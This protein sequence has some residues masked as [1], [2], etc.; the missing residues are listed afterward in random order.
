MQNAGMAAL[1][2]NWRYLAFDVR[3][4]ELR[5]A[6]AG[7]QAMQFVGLNLTVPHKL[8][9]VDMV[10]MLD[11]SARTWRAVNTIRFEGRDKTGT[12]PPLHQSETCPKIRTQGSTPTRTRSRARCA[13]IWDR[14]TA[15]RTR[16]GG[17][18]G[19]GGATAEA[20]LGD[21][22]ELFLVNRTQSKATTVAGGIRP[23]ITPN[24]RAQ[25]GYPRGEVDLAVNARSPGLAASDPVRWSAIVDGAAGRAVITPPMIARRKPLVAGQPGS[26]AAARRRP[27]HA[28][29]PGG[30][31]AR[32]LETAK[33]A[34]VTS[35]AKP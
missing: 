2:V 3:P 32:N 34:P 10:D 1:G 7:A 9:A 24:V 11:E 19:A 21:V 28:A 18:S 16:A 4:E 8:L 12:W 30:E 15:R 26:P 20:G 31:S 25:L 27:G 17:G 5:A 33:T 35:C 13:R 23:T 6:L 22:G 29:I 14:G